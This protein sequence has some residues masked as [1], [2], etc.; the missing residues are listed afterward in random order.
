MDETW[1]HHY[2]PESK[3][4]SKK[5]K[6]DGCSASKKP[7]SVPSAGKVVASVF[8]DAEG[9][10]FIDYLE[11]GKTI[12]GEYYSN[13]LTRLDEKIRE[14]MP[15][16]QKKKIVFHQDNAPTHKNVLAMGKLRDVH[17]ELLEHPPY[18]PDLAP[19]DFSLFPKLK[20]FLAGQRFSSNQE[21][22]A[23]VEGYFADLTKNHYRDRIMAL[24]HCWNKCISLKG[25]YVEK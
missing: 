24:E 3:Q 25:D 14:K 7:R 23:A 22:T 15:G 5:W 8:W 13:L 19:S 20:L 17:Y 10:L 6:E 9:I 4:Q 16:L 1:I 12:T 21:A 2:T 11:N 18:S